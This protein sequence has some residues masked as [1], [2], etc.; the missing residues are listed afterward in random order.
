M[1]IT[2]DRNGTPPLD[3]SRPAVNAEEAATLAAELFGITGTAVELGSQQDRNFRIDTEGESFLLKVLGAGTTDDDLE[4]QDAALHHLL[5]DGLRVP[6]PRTGRDGRTVQHATIGGTLVRV[7]LLSF[8]EGPS[9]VDRRYLAPSVVAAIGRLSATVALS[10]LSA[11]VTPPNRRLQ[12]DLRRAGDVIA[13]LQHT[14]PD[15]RRSAVIEASLGALARLDEVAPELRTQLIHGDLTDDNVVC[16]ADESGRLLPHGIIDFGDLAEGWLVAELAVTVSSLLHHVPGS[17]QSVLPAI[18]AFDEIIPLQ[19]A[20]LHALWPLIVLR[21]AV[22]VVSGENQVQLEAENEYAADRVEAE[23]RIFAEAASLAPEAAED[24]IRDALGRPPRA[25]APQGVVQEAP[26]GREHPL[27]VGLATDSRGTD[28][29]DTDSYGRLD[30]S[31]TSPL[32]D[33]GAWIPAESEWELAAVA[34][35]THSAAIAPYGRPRLTRATPLSRAEPETWPTVTDI[36]VVAGAEVVAPFPARSE[37]EGPDGILLTGTDWASGRVLHVAG[38]QDATPGTFAAGER[39]AVAAE[40]RPGIGRLRIQSRPGQEPGRGRPGEKPAP[41][42]VVPSQSAAWSRIA[43]NPEPL[44]GL[45]PDER[46][47]D[48]R[49]EQERRLAFFPVAQE[50]YY[51]RPPQIERGWREHLMDTDGRI[52]LDMV[53]NVAGVGHSDP[54][55]TDAVTRQLRKLNTNSRFL[56]SALADLSERLVDRAPDGLDTVLLVNSGTEAVDLAIRLAQLYTGRRLVVAL[57]EAYHGWSMAADAVTT[58]AFDNPQALATRPDWVH[59]TEAPNEYRGI[60]RGPDSGAQYRRDLVEE[61][62]QLALGG[63]RLAAFLCEPILGNAG[64]VILPNGYLAG[65]YEDVRARGGVCIADEIQVGYGRLGNHFWGVE[66]EGVVPDILTIAKA[67]GNGYPL[68]AVITR[69]EIAAALQNE[70]HFFSSAGGSPVSCAAGGAVLDIMEQDELQENARV[71]GAHLAGRLRELAER[72]PLI[73]RVHGLGLYLGVEFVRDRDT[74]EPAA[75]ETAAICERLLSLGVI[76]QPT[77]ER[78]NVLKI[79]PPLCLSLESADF[80]VDRLDEVLTDGW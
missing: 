28:S 66:Q 15:S 68:G 65:V 40:Q 57:R 78:Q 29:R 24:L 3:R 9:L 4:V 62:D 42:F 2:H 19:D 51:E 74:R 7:R 14:V 80:F 37:R 71:V 75:A 1:T 76:M 70:G 10:L 46:I 56:Y 77:S 49:E 31:T 73:G 6:Q 64:G 52:Y 32:L 67:M 38:V 18:R 34:L 16:H 36:F 45:R 61:I 27:V 39:I 21:G 79:K 53:N 17:L 33:D 11:P 25:D 8:L 55:L 72:H 43:P 41:D 59:I 60:H 47:A 69:R 5:V 58:S 63:A 20:E 35:S 54:R 50:K 48:S 22:L 30:F 26:E 13:T 44:L 23:W 12:W